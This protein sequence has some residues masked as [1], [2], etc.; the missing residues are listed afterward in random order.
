[1]V[2]WAHPITHPNGISICSALIVGLTNVT[3]RQTDTDT[4]TDH[5]TLS[6]TLAIGSLH[7]RFKEVEKPPIILHRV[8][9]SLKFRHIKIIFDLCLKVC[10][11][12]FGFLK[13]INRVSCCVTVLRRTQYNTY[14]YMFWHWK[15]LKS[16][17]LLTVKERT[18]L[19]H[20]ANTWDIFL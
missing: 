7:K 6:A 5:A 2:P 4:Q 3:N 16:L 8:L 1:M 18:I 10:W 14:V 20:Y 15:L 19:V 12:C 9:H 17:L 11:D 13:S